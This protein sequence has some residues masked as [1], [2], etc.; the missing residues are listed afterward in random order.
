MNSVRHKVCFTLVAFFCLNVN[1]QN[2]L[3]KYRRYFDE[4]MIQFL[5]ENEN[6]RAPEELNVKVVNWNFNELNDFFNAGMVCYRVTGPKFGDYIYLWMRSN[7][8]VFNDSNWFHDLE[9]LKYNKTELS[10]LFCETISALTEFEIKKNQLVIKNDRKRSGY[11]FDIYG[12]QT[13]YLRGELEV[14]CRLDSISPRLNHVIKIPESSTYKLFNANPGLLHDSLTG[15]VRG[16]DIYF[17]LPELKKLFLFS[18]GE[19]T[20]LFNAFK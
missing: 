9:V 12:F 2:T 17:Y 18:P 3:I 1:A 20:W 6:V 16:R 10:K 8:L 4:K 5:I 15:I 13:Y 11:T 19:I 7:S 14:N